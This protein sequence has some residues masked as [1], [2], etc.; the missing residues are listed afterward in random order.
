MGFTLFGARMVF[1]KGKSSADPQQCREELAG[2]WQIVGWIFPKDIKPRI[3]IQN[4]YGPYSAECVPIC[5]PS[6]WIFD[7]SCTVSVRSHS[8]RQDVL[9]GVL[10]WSEKCAKQR[11]VKWLENYYSFS[12]AFKR[13]PTETPVMHSGAQQAS[14]QLPDLFPR[15]F[16]AARTKSYDQN[17]AS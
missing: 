17:S 5:S 14:T 11:N 12:R 8:S 4:S 13:R 2:S 6:C 10:C 7:S 16:P 15:C 3:F 1:A 9:V